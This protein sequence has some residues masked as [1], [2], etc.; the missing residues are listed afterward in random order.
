MTRA[1]ELLGTD[2]FRHAVGAVQMRAEKQ[3]DWSKVLETFVRSDLLARVNSPDSQLILGRR[4]TGKTHLL[5][6]FQTESLRGGGV[7]YMFDCT[8]LGSAASDTGRSPEQVATDYFQVFLNQLGTD[9]LDELDRSHL[10]S[11]EQ[12]DVIVNKL[13]AGLTP[14][15]ANGSQC[16]NFRQISDTL[17]Q[18]LRDMNIGKLSVVLD[19]W[20]QVPFDSQPFFAEFVKRTLLTVPAITVKVLAV[21]YQCN[22][23]TRVG[24]NPVGM[25]RGA[26]L[27]NVIDMDR[28][29]VWDEKREFVT[30]FFAQLLYNHLGIELRLDL[31]VSGD[32]KRKW[33]EE[34][35]TQKNAFHELV[36]AAEGNPRD[37]LCIFAK[38]YFDEYKSVPGSKSI[39][40][41][42]IVNAAVAW[43][44]ETKAKNIVNEKSATET[45]QH[46]MN[47]VLKGYKARTFMVE[48]EKAEHPR[49]IRLLNERILHRLSGTYSHPDRPGVRHDLF[50]IDYGAFARF[51]G[52]KNAIH[53]EA[54]WGNHNSDGLTAEEK[55]Q[56]V[57]VDDKRSIRRITFDPDTL[58]TTGDVS[59]G[60]DTG[61][62]TSELFQRDSGDF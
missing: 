11:N 47:I 55:T 56:L 17:T 23:L 48:V 6:V 57:P 60:T 41:P 30:E 1:I 16:L 15:G 25:E 43:Y 40:V 9:F 13:A 49:L 19:E 37:F 62:S 35:F 5:R 34:L 52:T 7:V 22:L 28:Y 39:S 46:I 61:Q 3:T 14:S 8:N 26:D 38:A 33:T 20:A 10:L 42:N 32:E 45:L 36:R 50:A 27:P 24:N 12:K 31:D 18:V 29:L 2:K 54:F 51:R 59:A 58:E 4:G 21:N 44:D 53:E